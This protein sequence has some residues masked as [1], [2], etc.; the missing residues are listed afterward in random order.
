MAATTAHVTPESAFGELYRGL[1][2]RLEQIVR[3]D[4]GAPEPVVED[5]CQFAWG[6]LLAQATRIR[7]EVALSW[8]STT[9]VREARRLMHARERD[10]SLEISEPGVA[11]SP[12]PGALVP[13]MRAE[14]DSLI[15]DREQLRLMRLLPERQQRIL[16]LHA[17][18]LSYE[19]IAAYTGDSMRTV[20]RQLLRGR[21]RIRELA[22]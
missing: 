10:V 18:G 19:E 3:A 20:E 16:W 4:V 7:A 21:R 6:R 14:T 13:P 17:L 8:L 1:S 12:G 2:R 22:V 9:A 15:E 11:E 5:A